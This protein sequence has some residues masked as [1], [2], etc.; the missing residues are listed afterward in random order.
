MAT[1]SC[2]CSI[3]ITMSMASSPIVVFDGDGRLVGAVVAPGPAPQGGRECGPYSP[4]DPGRSQTLA[5]NLK[6]LLRADSPLFAPRRFWTCVTGSAGLC[7]RLSKNS[8]LAEKHPASGGVQPRARYG[9][10]H[11]GFQKQRPRQTFLYAARSLVKTPGRVIARVEV[12]PRGGHHATSSPI[13]RLA[14][15]HLYEKV[16]SP[17]G[18]PRTT[19]SLEGASRR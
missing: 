12:S 3:P 4:I 18:Q 17:W 13:S 5:Q 8:R 14:R 2:V 15:K 6:F 10:A 1:S 11:P 16:Y 7:L 19:S 9:P